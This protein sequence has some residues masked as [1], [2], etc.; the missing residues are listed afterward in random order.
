[1]Q[2]NASFRYLNEPNC[3]ELEMAVSSAVWRFL[4]ITQEALSQL[5]TATIETGKPKPTPG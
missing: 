3:L 4:K 2:I 5:K 1:M